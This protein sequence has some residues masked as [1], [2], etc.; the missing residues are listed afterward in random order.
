MGLMMEALKGHLQQNGVAF[1]EV[2]GDPAYL[3][4]GFVGAYARYRCFLVVHEQRGL[5]IFYTVYPLNVPE[6]KRDAIARLIS[7]AN[8][9]MQFGNFE[10]DA[11]DG[12]VRFKTSIWLEGGEALTDGMIRP[13]LGV[14]FTAVDRYMPALA[15]VIHAD[16]DPVEAVRQA[17]ASGSDEPN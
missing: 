7:T 10:M 6:A 15:K 12:E 1:E 5:V 17:E 13:L 16:M 9:G 11:G 8:Y 2:T 4:F 14:S 3:A